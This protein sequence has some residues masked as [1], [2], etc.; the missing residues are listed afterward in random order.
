MLDDTWIMLLRLCSYDYA[1]PVPRS[2]IPYALSST[3]LGAIRIPY[4]L[5]GTDLGDAGGA[6]RDATQGSRPGKPH[7]ISTGHTCVVLTPGNGTRSCTA[8]ASTVGTHRTTARVCTLLVESGGTN[9]GKEA[10]YSRCHTTSNG[11]THLCT[12]GTRQRCI[13]GT[14]RTTLYQRYKATLYHTALY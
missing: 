10:W 3:G 4:A 9:P 6:R 2:R 8:W 11:T 1:D 14:T 5:S 13:S 7:V 12:S